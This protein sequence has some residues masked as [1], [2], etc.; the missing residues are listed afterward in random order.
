MDYISIIG[1]TGSFLSL[2]ANIPQVYRV[3]KSNS[4]KD[5]HPYTV[6]IHIVSAIVW[7]TYGFLLH[8]PILGIESAIVAFLNIL[9]FLAIIRDKYFCYPHDTTIKKEIQIKNNKIND[10]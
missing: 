10:I 2:I 8:L 6:V 9:I 1:F 7:S 5:I 3:R 4:T